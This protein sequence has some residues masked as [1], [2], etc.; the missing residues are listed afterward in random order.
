MRIHLE[1]QKTFIFK[2]MLKS[3]LRIS[4]I[5]IGLIIL[6]PTQSLFAQLQPVELST[7]VPPRDLKK[8]LKKIPAVKKVKEIALS[9]H[10]KVCYEIWFEQQIDPKNEKAGTFLQLVY[11]SEYRGDAPVVAELEGYSAYSAKSNEL[12]SL[13]KANQ[14][15]IEHRYFNKSSPK[16]GIP[17]ET[18]TVENAAYDHHVIIN[19]L[20]KAIYPNNKFISTGISKGG[21]TT[22]LHRS[23]YPKDVDASV[24]YVAPLNFKREDSR[25]YSFLDAVATAEEREAVFNFQLLCL[26]KKK[27]LTALLQTVADKNGYVWDIPIELAF[28]YY[29]LEYSFAFWQWGAYE[30]NSLPTSSATNS[31]VLSHLLNVSGISFFEQQGVN[32]LRSYFWAALTEMGIYGY[33]YEPFKEYLSQQSDYLFDFTAPNGLSTEFD[34]A[35]MKKLNDFIQD[36]AETILFIYG[37]YDTWSATAVDLSIAAQARGLKKFVNPASHHDTR[38][39]SFNAETKD[40]IMKTIEGWIK[41]Q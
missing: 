1:S 35:P 18:L 33:Q 20:R 23:F 31:I 10:F 29:V 5:V 32:D 38:I 3:I 21:Q 9:D 15:R 40:E 17:W 2:H 11:L 30:A 28:E 16:K 19:A 22:M 13:L 36:E 24:C 6:H 4:L 7:S 26:Q 12:S 34:P 8:I 27:E 41:K 14:V 37:E 39:G 25:I